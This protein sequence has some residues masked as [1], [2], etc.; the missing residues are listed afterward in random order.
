MTKRKITPVLAYAVLFA[1]VAG[2]QSCSK[3]ADKLKFNLKMQTGSVHF[4]IPASNNTGGNIMYGPVTNSYNV[5]SFIKAQTATSLGISNITSVKIA[6]CVLTVDDPDSTNKNLGNFESAYSDFYSDVYTTPFRVSINNIPD[7]NTTSINI[8]VDTS[9]ELKSYIGTKFTYSLN[10][11]Q[12][13]AVPKDMHCTV[14]YAFNLVI[15]G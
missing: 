11:K 3:V 1:A 15:Q 14:S 7:V 6:S 13:R 4:I 2:F 10:A 5:D 9:A 8:P 12:R